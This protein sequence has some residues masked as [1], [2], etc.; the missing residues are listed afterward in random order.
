MASYIDIFNYLNTVPV[1]WLF[2]PVSEQNIRDRVEAAYL[3]NLPTGDVAETSPAS[4]IMDAWAGDTHL[5]GLLVSASAR[6][7][8]PPFWS[9]SVMD[10]AGAWYGER[11]VRL[12]NETDEQYHPR[13][14]SLPHEGQL[15]TEAGIEATIISRFSTFVRDIG[16]IPNYSTG[17][18]SLYLLSH[19]P[20]VDVT[21]EQIAM[22]K[23]YIDQNNVPLQRFSILNGQRRKV[24]VTATVNYFSSQV[25]ASVIESEVREAAATWHRQQYILNGRMIRSTLNRAMS[26]EAVRDIVFTRYDLATAAAQGLQNAMPAADT[27]RNKGIAYYMALDEA[28]DFTLSFVGVSE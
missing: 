11:G 21:A 6:A 25:T 19:D 9:G 1:T 7:T 5:I 23:D 10:N 20:T 12:E 8:C 24:V 16:L 18:I 26:V 3:A 14:L 17:I 22:V 15:I 28:A 2:Q 13:L 4:H 27:G